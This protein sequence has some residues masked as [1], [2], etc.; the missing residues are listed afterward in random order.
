MVVKNGTTNKKFQLNC[1]ELRKKLTERGYEEQESIERVQ[2]FDRNGLS[3]EKEKIKYN[4]DT[5]YT[6]LH[7]RSAS[8][9]Y[10]QT[11]STNTNFCI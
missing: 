5:T 3:K 6:H 9:L 10:Q 7:S 8:K 1:N 2:T 11:L 4:L